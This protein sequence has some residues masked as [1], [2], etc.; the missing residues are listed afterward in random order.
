MRSLPKESGMKTTED[1]LCD[2]FYG[3]WRDQTAPQKMTS[4]KAKKIIADGRVVLE[5]TLVPDQMAQST[6]DAHMATAHK[7]ILFGVS[8]DEAKATS[9]DDLQKAHRIPK[10]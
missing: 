10:K 5:G 9:M 6:F 4:E 7:V 3:W 1:L 8:W 2:V